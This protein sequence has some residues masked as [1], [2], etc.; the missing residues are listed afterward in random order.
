MIFIAGI[1]IAIFIEFLLL[2]KKN[3]SK[4]D[5][6]LVLWMFLMIIHLFL[7][8]LSHTQIIYEYP[9]LLGVEM[10]MP[11]L[12]GVLLYFYVGS[13]TNQLPKNKAL[14]SLHFLPSLATYLY[15][16]TFFMLPAVNKIEV[17][18]NEGVGY[19]VFMAILSVSISLSGVLY[20]L[21]S[22]VLLRRHKRNILSRFSDLE[23][24]DLKWL[25]F[26][27]W[28]LGGIW[29]IVIFSE[30]GTEIFL[31]LVVFIFL[32]GFFGIRQG[33]I[34]SITKSS[35]F[36][37][38][39]KTEKVNIVTP[40]IETFEKHTPKEKY[41]KSGLK[42]ADSEHLY[43]RLTTLMTEE[44]VYKNGE[45]SIRELATTLDVHPNYLSQ[46][47]NEREGKNFYDFVNGYRLE[48]FKKL[49]KQP[50]SKNL[51]LLSLA[52]DSGFNSKS[53]FNR[54]FKRTTGLTPSQ[55][56]ASLNSG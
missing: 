56:F 15:L 12:H 25:Q 41:A 47:I 45:L 40:M 48:E 8:Y 35:A 14:L 18:K 29:I 55:Y 33:A 34:F 13:V 30:R 32:I 36:P 46:I 11:L 54:Y 1:S 21:W 37:D 50:K 10:P 3:K 49:L 6:T 38:P 44:F 2:S 52:Y 31:A 22:N 39:E 26:L 27:T 28:G 24:V 51:T 19:E 7:F 20:V 4:A 5:K 16:V 42:E 9:F 23:K 17:F 43:K 53:S